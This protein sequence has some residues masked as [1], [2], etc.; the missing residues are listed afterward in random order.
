MEIKEAENFACFHFP[1]VDAHGSFSVCAVD[2]NGDNDELGYDFIFIQ[3]LAWELT[4]CT[5]LH[6]VMDIMRKMFG[7]VVCVPVLVLECVNLEACEL[8]YCC[9]R[10]TNICQKLMKV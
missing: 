10:S 4:L 6:T 8:C 5:Y 3:D 9:S 2:G 7:F 1:H